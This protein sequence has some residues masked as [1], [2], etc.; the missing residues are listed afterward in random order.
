MKR[1]ILLFMLLFAAQVNAQESNKLY[2]E[3]KLNVA[4]A[5][6]AM[7]NPAVEIGFGDASA[8]QL[9]YMGA[10][11][12]EN[13]MGTGEPFMLS[14]AM[15]EYR[16]YLPGRGHKGFFA[17]LD[18]GLLQYHMSKHVIPF[19]PHD[20]PDGIYDVGYGWVAGVNLGYK[21]RLKNRLGLEIFAAFGFQHSWHEQYNQDGVRIYEMNK[22][23]EWLPYKGGI[24]LTYRFGYNEQ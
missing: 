21:F 5:A 6:V 24:S 14:M 15:A 7:F 17:G 10:Y 8:I 13:Y 22:T 4:M 11:A 19:V 2:V 3:P 20:H 9:E 23:A 1:V 18:L 12:R 16:T